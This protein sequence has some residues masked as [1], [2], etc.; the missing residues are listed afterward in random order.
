MR[1]PAHGGR[2]QAGRIFTTGRDGAMTEAYENGK[3]N[4]R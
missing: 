1:S 2:M 3:G 4:I